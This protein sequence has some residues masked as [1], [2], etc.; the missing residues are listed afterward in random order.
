MYD[1]TSDWKETHIVLL[2]NGL[3]VSASTK[4]AGIAAANGLQ[5]ENE[6]MADLG[7]LYTISH[8]IDHVFQNYFD[9]YEADYNKKTKTYKENASDERIKEWSKRKMEQQA[10]E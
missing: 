6:E 3:S 9:I 7:F 1:K 8:E 2:K 4:V 10:E 5:V